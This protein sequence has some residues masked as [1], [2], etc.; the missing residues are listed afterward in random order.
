M[1]PLR[2]PSINALAAFDAAARH[3]SFT[4]AGEELGISREAVS[5]HIRNL[6]RQLGARLFRRVHRAVELTDAGRRY[7]AT[8][9]DCLQGLAAAAAAL[10]R[11][12]GPSRVT[13]AATI[14]IASF[15]LTPRLPRFRARHPDVELRVTAS[16]APV[17]TAMAGVDLGLRYGGGVWPGWTARH[18]FDVESFP[19]CAP[20]YLR[21]AP[22][23]GAPADLVNHTL[24]NLD[25]AAHAAEDWTW[26]LAQ[27]GVPES[28]AARRLG[29]DSYANV[30]D[31]AVQGQGVALGFGRIIGSLLRQGRLTRPIAATQ[32]RGHAVYLLVPRGAT[33]TPDAQKFADWIRAEAA[34][35]GDDAAR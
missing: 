3:L 35:D 31:A 27:A 10:E 24:L 33:L 11:G 34:S 28:P 25:G 4:R 20:D 22:P 17:E 12:G 32:T 8:V 16:D 5:R 19:V 15:W 26:W 18:L 13:V 6:E 7:Q 1:P 2:L 23:L 14:A 30:I 9:R 29:F 21:Q